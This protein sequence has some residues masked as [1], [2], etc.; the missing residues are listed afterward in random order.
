MS[1]KGVGHRPSTVDNAVGELGELS[2][3]DQLVPDYTPQTRRGSL[4]AEGPQRHTCTQGRLLPVGGG[5]LAGAHGS[6]GMS[7]SPAHQGRS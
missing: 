6:L 1:Q 2:V 3:P 7:A 4:V 5:A